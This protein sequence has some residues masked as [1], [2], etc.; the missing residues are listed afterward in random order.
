MVLPSYVNSL[1][2]SGTPHGFPL[3]LSPF[4]PYCEVYVYVIVFA[5]IFKVPVWTKFTTIG[6]QLFWYAS[7][8][9]LDILMVGICAS[10][11]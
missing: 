5:F 2:T 9:P 11:C 4:E 1:A 6:A 8:N 10:W 7:Q 3:P